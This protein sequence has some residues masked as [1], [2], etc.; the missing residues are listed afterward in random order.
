VR[1][2][3]LPTPVLLDC[4]FDEPEGVLDLVRRHDPYWNQSRYQPAARRAAAATTPAG[5][6]YAMDGGFP[7]LFR[8]NWADD[9]M[10]VEGAAPLLASP[11]LRDA[12]LSLLGGAAC[13]PTFLY[14]NITAPMPGTDCGCPRAPT[15]ATGSTAKPNT[16]MHAAVS[17]SKL[18]PRSGARPRTDTGQQAWNPPLL[19]L[20]VLACGK[21]DNP[22]AL[23]ALD[24]P[25]AD[26]P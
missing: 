12:A 14:V 1:E 24:T 11:M 5:H 21:D 2:P 7:P 6:P 3:T 10:T 20:T 26:Q 23:A 19:E 13:D 8:G 4:V 9:S 25:A 22:E 18:V 17:A 16:A 15:P